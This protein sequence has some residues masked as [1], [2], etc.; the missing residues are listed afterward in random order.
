MFGRADQ[1]VVVKALAGGATVAAAARAAGFV[2]QTLYNQRARCGLFRSA[3]DGAVEESGR[4]ML[5]AP[6]GGRLWQAQRM[7]RNRFTR[8][9]KLAFLSHFAATCDATAS[10]EAAGVCLATVYSHRRNDPAFAAGWREAE[11]AGYVALEAEMVRQR[12]EAMERYDVAPGAVLT[13]RRKAN[14]DLEF[15]R[16]MH[17]LREHKRS[18]NGIGKA[19]RP[20]TVATNAEVRAA[21]EKALKAF[22]RRAAREAGQ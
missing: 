20:P 16:A 13:P 1:A 3:W 17:L 21:L 6:R 2:V 11:E 5:V 10:A 8:E 19:G 12:I 9:R 18:L 7:R 4:P 15:W 14:R 22:Q